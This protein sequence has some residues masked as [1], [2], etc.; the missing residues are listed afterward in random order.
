MS[1]LFSVAAAGFLVLTIALAPAA[2]S[3]CIDYPSFLEL[4]GSL[5]IGSDNVVVTLDGSRAYIGTSNGFSIVDI[6]NPE[7]PLSLASNISVGSSGLVWDIKISGSHAIVI[8]WDTIYAVD[9][10]DPNNPQISDS[11]SLGAPNSVFSLALSGN[12][13]FVGTTQGVEVFDISNPNSL[14]NVGSEN[15]SGSYAYGVKIVGTILYA[16]TQAGLHAVDISNPASPSEIGFM[17]TTDYV[18][19]LDVVGSHA[20]LANN[21]DGLVI[22]DVTIPSNPVSVSSNDYYG[23]AR[24][25]KVHSGFAYVGDGGTL[26]VFDVSDPMNPKVYGGKQVFAY[27]LAIQ[28][29][30]AFTAS[31][32][33]FSSVD[34]SSIVAPQL[35]SDVDLF[36]YANDVVVVGDNAYVSVGGSDLYVVDISNPGDPQIEG[37]VGVAGAGALA[38]QSPYVYVAHNGFDIVDVSDPTNPQLAG[39]HVL[40]PAGLVYDLKVSGSYV[41]ATSSSGGVRVVDVSNPLSPSQVTSFGGTGGKLDIS[42]NTL[43]HTGSGY[44]TSVD[45]SN[46]LSPQ[47]LDNFSSGWTLSDVLVSG[48]YLYTSDGDFYVIDVTNPSNLTD[49]GMLNLGGNFGWITKSG[50]FVY[51]TDDWGTT[52]RVDVIDVSDPAN[53]AELD[54]GDVL[55]AVR[56][57]STDGDCLY[58]AS[59]NGLRTLALHCPQTLSV[60]DTPVGIGV[61]TRAFPNPFFASTQFV[62]ELP[63]TQRVKVSVYDVQGRLVTTL[64]DASLPQGMS[65]MTWNGL[66]QAGRPA[67]SGVYFIAAAGDGFQEASRVTLL[68]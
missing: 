12:H 50:D 6:T 25:I 40:A 7:T 24:R 42:G 56:G 5:S 62:I 64:S 53:P 37:S 59:D 19:G 46:P 41:Y 10:T 1:K 27:G 48:S 28:G 54:R 4:V 29:N 26:S 32:F 63:S 45:I 61:N 65:T 68:R 51:G 57:V 44:L 17:P 18:Y 60:G 67:P 47:N 38:Y 20:Y 55:N 66:D 43:Y 22:A 33:L 9:V 2:H 11:Q 34:I 15:L 52:D 3:Q 13:A 35:V 58:L 36:A 16:G 31:S 49:V 8:R 39:S 30:M 23:D 21:D 14:S